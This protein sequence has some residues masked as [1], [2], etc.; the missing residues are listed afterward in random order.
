MASTVGRLVRQDGSATKVQVS[1]YSL[2]GCQ[3]PHELPLGELVSV[4]FTDVAL[5]VGQVSA[6]QAGG[7]QIMFVGC[8]SH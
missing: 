1:Q 8:G 3:I 4:E 2:Q 5:L 7:S 6:S